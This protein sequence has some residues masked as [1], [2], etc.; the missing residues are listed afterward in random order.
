MVG[1]FS[2]RVVQGESVDPL[3]LAL[4]L[5][6]TLWSVHAWDASFRRVTRANSRAARA[7]VAVP[8][9]LGAMSYSLY[10]LHPRLHILTEQI[11]RQ[12]VPANSL[13]R[14]GLVLVLICALCYPFYR[15]CEASFVRARVALPEKRGPGVGVQV[16]S[17]GGSNG[18]SCGLSPSKGKVDNLPR[19]ESSFD[20]A[21]V[22]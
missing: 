14:D 6:G 3:V 16:A 7:L 19:A 18:N 20:N 1:A 11:T 17:T 21:V 13:A 15:F 22:S 8:L 2:W 4:A 10:L 5:A 9:L 12:A